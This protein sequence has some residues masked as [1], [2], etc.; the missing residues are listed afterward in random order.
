MLAAF[1]TS[2]PCSAVVKSTDFAAGDFGASE[3]A[4][5]VSFGLAAA[6]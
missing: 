1:D 2:L 6:A 5:P 4:M 3:D